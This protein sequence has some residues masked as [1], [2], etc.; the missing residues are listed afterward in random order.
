MAFYRSAGGKANIWT[1]SSVGG[2]S[3]QI[4]TDGVTVAGYSR[5]PIYKLQTND[6]QWSPDSVSL[7]YC[8]R[9]NNTSNLFHV[10]AAGGPEMQLTD[11]SDPQVWLYSPFLSPDG[12][13]IAYLRLDRPDDQPTKKIWSIWLLEGGELKM[14]YRSDSAS[15]ILGWSNSGSELFVE[16]TVGKNADTFYPSTVD[17][18]EVSIAAESVRPLHR[19]EGGYPKS[20]VISPDRESI[21]FVARNGNVDSLKVA[22]VRGG[23]P[24]TIVKS[25]DER[26]YFASPSWTSDGKSIIFGKQSNWQIIS[27]IEN[28]K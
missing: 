20:V 13:K 12:T 21:V 24:K 27:M 17:I 11:I 4:T 15:G 25:N 10:G 7:Y 2:R 18:L 22:P 28:F 9:R 1:V 5:F 6:Y 26:V 14:L 23:V 16:S 19:I 3:Q 8:A